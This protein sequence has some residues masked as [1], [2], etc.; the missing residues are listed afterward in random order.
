VDG[1]PL[2]WLG[3][4]NG[5]PFPERVAGSS[6][7]LRLAS[8]PAPRPLRIHFFGGEPGVAQRAAAR[9]PELGG[10]L[11]DAGWTDP[12]FGSVE[13][14]GSVQ[15][16]E[17]IN[18]SGADLLVLALGAK[19]GHEWIARNRDRVT[20]PVI[21][22]LGATVNFIAG[23]VQRA[24]AW[25]QD[26]GLEWIWRILQ[27]PKLLRRYW[28]DGLM[29]LQM[30]RQQAPAAGASSPAGDEATLAALLASPDLPGTERHFDV[31]DAGSLDARTLGLLYS[32]RYRLAQRESH[33]LTCS[34]PDWL[35][36]LRQLRADCLL[37][38]TRGAA[39]VPK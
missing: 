25:V 21:S 15:Y 7:L 5:I 29:F 32:W 6:L 37:T 19:K 14:M 39:P 35:A 22:H 23:T 12:G 13:S 30:L 10:G 26:S 31:A 33:R 27:E 36:L 20:V 9:L 17:R 28:T 2:V 34:D 18:G 8:D 4:R 3:R 16:I 24:P 38:G 1:M 11:V